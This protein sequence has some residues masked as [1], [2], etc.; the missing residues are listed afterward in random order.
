MYIGILDSTSTIPFM[1]GPDLTWLINS[2]LQFAPLSTSI[3]AEVYLL[4]G[5]T[6]AECLY[7]N[8]LHY[9]CTTQRT[10][11]YLFHEF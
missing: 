2:E 8:D 10:K 9:M 3:P 11:D 5:T 7:G 1:S 6:V 4:E